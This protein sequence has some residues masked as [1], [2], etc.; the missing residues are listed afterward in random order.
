MNIISDGEEEVERHHTHFLSTPSSR[1]KCYYSTSSTTAANCFLIMRI[2]L[3]G[4][5][6]CR[7]ILTRPPITVIVLRSP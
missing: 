3:G 1:Q 7:R 6:E 4:L 5:L 2:Q